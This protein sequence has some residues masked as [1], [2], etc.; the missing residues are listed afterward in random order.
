M[1]QKELSLLL[2][3][4][5]ALLAVF[6]AA[7]L[8][9]FLPP[10]THEVELFCLDRG[11]SELLASAL[12]GCAFPAVIA[13]SAVPCFAALWLAFAIFTQ[14]GKNNSFCAE[15]ARRLRIIS[16]LA[17]TDT[18]IY[19]VL[20]VLL[21]A[22]GARH[23]SIVLVFVS[24]VLCGAAVTVCAAALSHLTKKAADLKTDS[25]LTI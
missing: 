12:G 5:V 11:M 7:A 6:L 13:L 19:A 1:G 25:D 4:V 3:A 8:I 21:F 2:R 18:F 17:L 23:P 20:A 15:N 14:I 16:R 9:F 24:I 22:L 10:L